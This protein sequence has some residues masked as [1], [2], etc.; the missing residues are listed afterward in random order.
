MSKVSAGNTHSIGLLFERYHAEL[1]NFFIKTTGD[2][3]ASSDLTQTVF[4]RILRYRKS[5]KK[6]QRFRPWMYQ[7][8]RNVRSDEYKSRQKEGE[9]GSVDEYSVSL[10]DQRAEQ[11]ESS[12]ER[13]EQLQLAMQYMSE[14]K[15]DLITYSILMNLPSE[16]VA[17]IFNITP[18]NARVRLHRALTELKEVYHKIS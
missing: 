14:E 5:Y 3:E 6:D 13:I 15:K 1:Y 18:N 7:I 17:E 8:A 11:T 9:L 4:Y 12:E 10:K 2:R 16:E